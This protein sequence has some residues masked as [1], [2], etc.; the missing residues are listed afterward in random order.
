MKAHMKTVRDEN[1]DDEGPTHCE[2]K[3]FESTVWRVDTLDQ[4]LAKKL[5]FPQVTTGDVLGGRYRLR[6]QLGS[7]GMGD[8]YLAENVTLGMPVA[9][10][11]LRP[12]LLSDP[13][14]RRRFQNEAQ[15]IAS[16]RHPCIARFLD[17]VVGEPTFLVMDFVPGPT[18]LSVL[19]REKRLHLDRVLSNA[20]QLC[21]ALQAVHAAGIIHRDV[22]P[23]NVILTPD[24]ERGEIPTLID[25]GLAKLASRSNEAL[26]RI[27]T[28]VG[29]PQYMA[30]EQVSGSA[31][32]DCRADV[33]SMG[34]LLYEM[35]TGC[36][37]F[38]ASD[39]ASVL[40]KQ[41]REQHEP[42]SKL[43]PDRH[44]PRRSLRQRR[45]LRQLVE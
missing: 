40:R 45:Q 1:H 27:G 24:Y 37:P 8:V 25:F 32:I 10:K 33:Y 26:T 20:F 3:G 16:L 2:R 21:W 43:A 13:E 31:E 41:L 12:V 28:A 39:E 6:Q 19:E 29:T 23:A 9:I 7:G 5:G 42:I 14:F 36:R 11:I 18:L 4:D 15:A 44:Q 17:I 30:P 38:D 34:C 35:L 22:K